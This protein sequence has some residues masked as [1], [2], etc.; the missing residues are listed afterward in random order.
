MSNVE[1]LIDV[2]K[3]SNWNRFIVD[4]TEKIR[5]D[6]KEKLVMYLLYGL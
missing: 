2:Y 4:N 3:F 1:N 6:F 5:Y